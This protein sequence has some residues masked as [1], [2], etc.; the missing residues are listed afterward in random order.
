MANGRL[1]LTPDNEEGND[2]LLTRAISLPSYAIK[3]LYGALQPLSDPNSWEPYGNMT[4]EE[5][6]GIFFDAVESMGEC[7]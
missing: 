1:W 2:V 3:Y 4:P 5:I 6:A 7:P